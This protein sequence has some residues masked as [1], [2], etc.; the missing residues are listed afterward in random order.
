MIN[1]NF[2]VDGNLTIRQYFAIE[3]LKGILSS[4]HVFIE[5][6][7]KQKRN[8]KLAIKYTDELI[9]RLNEK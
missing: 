6:E 3:A 4:K 7:D 8:V 9:K 1:P 2:S 5:G